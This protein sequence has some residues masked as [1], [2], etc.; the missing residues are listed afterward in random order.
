MLLQLNMSF[1]WDKNKNKTNY[2]KHGLDFEDAA[3]VFEGPTLTFEDDRNDMEKKRYITLGELEKRTVII[4]HT[5]RNL[6]ICI[7]SMR[8]ANERETQ[9]YQKRLKEIRSNER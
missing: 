9:I 4:V 3:L 5:F 8:K 2:E 7:I 6:N 1:E